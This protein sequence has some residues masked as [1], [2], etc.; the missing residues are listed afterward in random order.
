MENTRH[1]TTV[2]C[3]RS[4]RVFIANSGPESGAAGSWSAF[5]PRESWIRRL[6]SIVSP[7]AAEFQKE[8]EDCSRRRCLFLC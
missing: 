8:K 2:F 5:F 7:K 4:L 1:R 6:I 3:S